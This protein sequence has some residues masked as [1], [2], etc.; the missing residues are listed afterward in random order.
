MTRLFPLI[1]Y[2]VMTVMLSIMSALGMI[3]TPSIDTPVSTV[4]PDTVQMTFAA[5]GDPQVSNYL[6]KREARLVSA[7]SDIKNSSV[8]LDALVIAGDI[9]ENGLESEYRVVAENLNALKDKVDDFI[10]AYGNHDSRLKAYPLQSKRIMKFHN[11]VSTKHQLTDHLYYS[12]EVKGYKFIVLN[13]D[14]TMFEEGYYSPE[15]LE[16]LDSEI[17]STQGSGKPVF[18]VNHQ[19]LK[20]SHGL[21][22]T[23]NAPEC[24]DKGSI[25]EQSDQIQAIFEKYNN[26]IFIT[27]HLHMGFGQYTY[28]DRG[29]YKLINLPTIGCSNSDGYDADGQG[30]IFE[31]YP[32]RIIARARVFS[33]G[34]YM[35]QYD[36]TIPLNY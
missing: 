18:V 31:V 3:S 9:A 24:L 6:Y 7:C 32:D 17:A 30:Y 10:I 8:K 15:Q 16:W 35:P 29:S 33:T 21:P 11:S 36:I 26:V 28:E 27:G 4:D 12:A 5:W 1:A 20:K 14:K 34:E 13:N 19:P 22:K 25:G 2:K 23:W